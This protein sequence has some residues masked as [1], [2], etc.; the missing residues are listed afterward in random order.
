MYQKLDKT[1][2]HESAF[3]LGAMVTN[4]YSPNTAAHSQDW[5]LRP[6]QQAI[7]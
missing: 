4:S 1:K 6:S 3:L 7:K 5:I 2:A